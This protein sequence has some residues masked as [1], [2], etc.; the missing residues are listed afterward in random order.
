M[1]KS[2][3][4]FF[5]PFVEWGVFSEPEG[6]SL[7][8]WSVLNNK[9]SQVWVDAGHTPKLI[10]LWSMHTSDTGVA[11]NRLTQAACMASYNSKTAIETA[12][13]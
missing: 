6:A 8:K 2:E 10:A 7:V 12:P 5:F 13:F 3:G 11:D 9:S 1:F 4:V